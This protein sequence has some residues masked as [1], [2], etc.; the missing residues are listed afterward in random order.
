MKQSVFLSGGERKLNILFTRKKHFLRK[1][2][3]R[4]SDQRI[5]QRL[6]QPAIS[7][8]VCNVVAVNMLLVSERFIH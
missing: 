4:Y 5:F 8:Q 3:T 7:R 2:G 6:Q 1:A